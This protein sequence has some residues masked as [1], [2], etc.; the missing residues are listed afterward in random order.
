MIKSFPGESRIREKTTLAIR[1]QP[2]LDRMT[3]KSKKAFNNAH[4]QCRGPFRA[5]QRGIFY[6]AWGD[7]IIVKIDDP[8]QWAD[9]P[10]SHQ[11]GKII[12]SANDPC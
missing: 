3:A 1:V 2:P 11:N 9:N 4:S 8:T 6:I 5:T 7:S 12:G 10:N